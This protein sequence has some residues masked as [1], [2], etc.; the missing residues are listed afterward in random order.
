MA[1]VQITGLSESDTIGLRRFTDDYD[2][3]GQVDI[4]DTDDDNDGMS[5]VYEIGFGF[6]N[7]R[8]ASDGDLDQDGDGASNLEEY[9]QGS[10]PT[11]VGDHANCYD[12]DCWPGFGSWRYVIPMP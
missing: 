8:D 7:S 5:D 10:N 12:S 2:N 11:E 9:L 1:F 3:D 4:F 6:L